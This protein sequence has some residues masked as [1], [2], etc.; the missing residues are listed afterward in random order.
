M[1]GAAEADVPPPP[2]L[3]RGEA[4]FWKMADVKGRFVRHLVTGYL[5]TNYRCFIWDVE[6][7]VV[8]VNVPMRIADVAVENNRP[9]KRARRGGSF[10]VP[11]TPDYVPPAMG[12]PVEIGDLFFR[13][14]GETVMVFR[15]VAE[16]LKVKALIDALR[17]HLNAHVKPPR[18]TGV[19]SLWRGAREQGVG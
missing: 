18:G 1:S 7:N 11:R 3:V 12:E 15:D 19:D 16:P 4:P 10:F 13:V 5:V 17:A 14:K 2:D 9:G 8:K 6:A